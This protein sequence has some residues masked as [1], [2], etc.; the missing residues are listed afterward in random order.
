MSVFSTRYTISSG[1][2]LFPLLSLHLPMC[3]LC[4][5]PP[6]LVIRYMH[7]QPAPFVLISD[8]PLIVSTNESDFNHPLSLLN[9]ATHGRPPSQRSLFVPVF[10][11][12]TAAWRCLS[13]ALKSAMPLRLEDSVSSPYTLSRRCSLFS[14][15][16]PG[17]LRLGQIISQVRGSACSAAIVLILHAS[18]RRYATE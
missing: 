7:F 10:C 6:A 8:S 4:A 3:P 2:P 18:M 11:V 9:H 13:R 14:S 12:F 15:T 1:R 5:I 17:F 16:L